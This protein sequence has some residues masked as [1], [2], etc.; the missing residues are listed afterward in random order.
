MNVSLPKQL[1]D[2]VGQQVRS[3]R[4]K[5]GEEVIRSAL[6]QMQESERDHELQSFQAAFRAIDQHS[7]G[8]EPTP[9]DLTQIDQI[10]KSVRTARR[11]KKAA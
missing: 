10:I 2:F 7:P 4:F 1:D 8:G 6:R 5:N 11:R 3:G 9:E